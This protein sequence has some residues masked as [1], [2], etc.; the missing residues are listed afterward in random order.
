MGG[1]DLQNNLLDETEGKNDMR[2]PDRSID[3]SGAAIFGNQNNL[4][5]RT[6]RPCR[7]KSQSPITRRNQSDL[8]KTAKKVEADDAEALERVFKKHFSIS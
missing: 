2:D 3:G 5:I 7:A 8:L 4:S 6:N 1:V